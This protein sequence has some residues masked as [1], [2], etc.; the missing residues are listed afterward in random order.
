M[1]AWLVSLLLLSTRGCRDSLWTP[2][3][4]QNAIAEADSPNS[5]RRSGR[6]HHFHALL[7]DRSYSCV[8]EPTS[9]YPMQRRCRSAEIP[10]LTLPQSSPLHTSVWT[11][12][13]AVAFSIFCES[14][15]YRS[16]AALSSLAVS[17]S[18]STY[19]PTPSSSSSMM[20]SGEVSHCWTLDWPSR[21]YSTLC[22]KNECIRNRK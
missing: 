8:V 18:S 12:A 2:T 20:Q 21:F 13:P 4:Q 16:G 14:F 3:V 1:G 17:T 22:P 5:E 6:P 11:A 7:S 15:M 10:L 9:G 19:R